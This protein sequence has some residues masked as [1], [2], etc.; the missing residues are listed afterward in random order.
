MRPV[1]TSADKLLRGRVFYLRNLFNTDGTV[2][3][4]LQIAVLFAV[5]KLAWYRG[6]HVNERRISACFCLL[7]SLF[8]PV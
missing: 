5:Q 8:G 1:Y 3:I 2:Q 4:M 6:S 7:K